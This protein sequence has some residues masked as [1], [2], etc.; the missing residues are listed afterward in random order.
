[1]MGLTRSSNSHCCSSKRRCSQ[2]QLPMGTAIHDASR[3][4]NSKIF[5]AALADVDEKQQF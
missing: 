4:V 5:A 2:R 1:M 3:V